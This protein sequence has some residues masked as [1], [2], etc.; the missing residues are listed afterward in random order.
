M[1]N[2]QKTLLTTCIISLITI[3][4]AIFVQFNAI[5]K[6]SQCSYLDPIL[7]DIL[8][9]SAA[10]FLVIEGFARIFEHPKATLK[11]QFTRIVR[12]SFGFAILTLHII[13][14]IHK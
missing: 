7:V 4:L 10:L 6:V 5:S 12:I 2:I 9:F 8:A 3:I 13:Q 14:F 1:K 11:R